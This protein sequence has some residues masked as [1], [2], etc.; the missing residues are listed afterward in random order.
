[1]ATDDRSGRGAWQSLDSL[2]HGGE[3]L[4][5]MDWW[6]MDAVDGVCEWECQVGKQEARRGGWGKGKKGQH[7]G[8][9]QRRSVSREGVP[10]TTFAFLWSPL[11]LMDCWL[12]DR[13][14]R[15]RHER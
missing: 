2:P 1:V 5:M 9:Q 6:E 13:V 3:G 7:V 10:F 4:W 15:R 14:G 11:W 8:P 12:I